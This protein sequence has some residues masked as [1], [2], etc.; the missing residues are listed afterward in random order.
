MSRKEKYEML[1]KACLSLNPITGFF[2]SIW[3]DYDNKFRDERIKKL[4][5]ELNEIKESL[6]K[7][8][9]TDKIKDCQFYF[10]VEEALN[11]FV[12][13]RTKEKRY[14]Y[15]CCILNCATF[16]MSDYDYDM[17]DKILK[18][19]DSITRTELIVLYIFKDI[20]AIQHAHSH[21]DQ[22]FK[23]INEICEQTH[24]SEDQLY[25][26]TK[27][28]ESN[29]LLEKFSALIGR[30]K[31]VVGIVDFSGNKYITELGEQ[32]LKYIIR[33]D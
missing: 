2:S 17:A 13:E 1:G 20:K 21:N 28:L 30:K 7:L 19:L 10:F 14:A 18:I 32:L 27:S 33:V 26:V 8:I 16:K 5:N 31:G 12:H 3:N 24:L 29:Y 23:L 25:S 11:K 15:R 22:C 4:N 6:E 9:T